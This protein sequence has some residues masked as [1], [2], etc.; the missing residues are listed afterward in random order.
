MADDLGTR[1][2]ARIR[3]LRGDRAL[4]LSALA[5]AAGIGK[6]SL[7]ELESGNRNPTLATLYA[8]AG[9]LRVPLA[10]LLGDEPGT[11]VADDGVRTRLLDA[12]RRPDG[13]TVEVYRLTLD[14][15]ARRSSPA[16]GPGVVEH[17]VGTD[18]TFRITRGDGELEVVEVSCGQSAAWTSDVSHSYESI[19]APTAE[20]I[21]VITTPPR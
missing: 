18:G 1:V 13:T 12:T 10:D 2:G 4:S 20:G 8:L 11:V 5:A 17:L 7:S 16:H 21:L 9:P 6:G 15:G 19:G 3:A 14:A